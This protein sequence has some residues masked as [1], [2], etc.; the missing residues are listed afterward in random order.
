MEVESDSEDINGGDGFKDDQIK[1]VAEKS[2]L[3]PGSILRVKSELN[4]NKSELCSI[5]C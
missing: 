2:S 3:K 1:L 4:K 5:Q